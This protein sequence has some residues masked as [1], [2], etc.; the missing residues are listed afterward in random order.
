M[1][2]GKRH[3]D[4]TKRR[5]SDRKR[6]GAPEPAPVPVERGFVRKESGELK[7]SADSIGQFVIMA[8]DK[9]AETS[10][11]EFS[12]QR[13][14][15]TADRGFKCHGNAEAS[16]GASYTFE[17]HGV[18]PDNPDFAT[19]LGDIE[20]TDGIYF[21]SSAD[22]LALTLAERIQT[23]ATRADEE[24]SGQLDAGLL[25]AFTVGAYVKV[26]DFE[27][28]IHLRLEQRPPRALPQHR[29]NNPA[30]S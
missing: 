17:I 30:T 24:I 19:W 20:A 25:Y 28:L 13:A 29:P 14:G 16:F 22:A 23:L 15:L 2:Q 9:L 1:S 21:E 8:F 10:L 4:G 27:M 5:T 7:G 12:E 26:T 6:R 3:S 11:K 18:T